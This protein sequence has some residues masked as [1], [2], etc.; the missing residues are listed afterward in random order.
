MNLQELRMPKSRLA[1]AAFLCAS[2]GAPAFAVDCAVPGVLCVPEEQ[3]DL[4]T[5][6]RDVPD[7][8]TIDIA[9]GTYPSPS[10]GNGFQLGTNKNRSFTVRARVSGQVTLTGQN[11]RIVVSIRD[12]NAA[13]WITFEGLRFVNGRTT[14]ADFAGG[15]SL[16]NARATFFDCEFTG[17]R[18]A[19]GNGGAGL[20]LY[21]SA[22]A[23]II[24]SLFED[25]R[26]VSDGAAI[27][28]QKG[29]AAP[30]NQPSELWI[31]GSTFRNN[32]ETGAALTDCTSGDGA[33]GAVL[34]RNSHA[35]IA[36]SLFE[37]NT[38]GYVGGAIYAYG[39]FACN[40]PYCAAPAADLLIVRSR[41]LANSANGSN[42]PARTE[43]GA[44]HVEDCARARIYQS[45]FEDNFADWGG[46][47]ETYRGRIVVFD[48]VLR[49]NRA[50][51]TGSAAPQGGT[52]LA[53]SGPAT[54]SPGCASQVLRDWP[55]ASL[56]V[57]RS[58]IEGNSSGVREAQVG[59]CLVASGDSSSPVTTDCQ[60]TDV[61]RCA[62]VK[63]LDTALFDC[64]VGKLATPDY[65]YGGG[66]VLQTAHATL[67][68]VLVA[69][70]RAAGASP[71]CPQGGGG[72][73]RFYTTAAMTDV[74]FSGNTSDCQNP[75]LQNHLS[76][77]EATNVRYRTATS[78]SPA[79]GKLLALPPKRYD[80][81]AL[82]PAENWLAWGW[83]GSAATLDAL[84][85]SNNPKNGRQITGTGVHQLD[86]AGG[87]AGDA[88][89]SVTAAV[90]PATTLSASTVCPTVSTTLSWAVP[91][92]GLLAAFVDQNVAGTS[93]TGSAA[94]TPAGTTTYR[95]VALTVEGGARDEVT[96]HVGSCPVIFVDG[97]QSGGTGAWSLTV[98]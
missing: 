16:R 83:S 52:I 48:S 65:V 2:I 64:S 1:A 24:D 57:E 79:D 71:L 6:F 94:V 63:I 21:G 61:N 10:G 84:T 66:F 3:A 46:A 37:N 5:A 95:R 13:R 42:A 78:T 76:T 49:G 51:S 26:G 59:G 58:L 39:Y 62:Q 77:L 85:L 9:P 44:I 11:A 40:A 97:F 98:P 28:A 8:G 74:L 75:D 4:A 96:V 69:R 19:G 20:G 50:T 32:C 15:V 70:N 25:N 90:T 60:T 35:R 86:V 22:K 89:A 82:V 34:I 67:T 88:A 14:A 81:T 30:N 87:A 27:F 72:S 53:M 12:L 68:D 93:A 55:A 54:T 18:A 80:D 38:A 41:F 7:G 91:S 31:L 36:D 23:L 29:S 33:G 43:A 17:N 45:T 47:L 56:H 92:G 73:I